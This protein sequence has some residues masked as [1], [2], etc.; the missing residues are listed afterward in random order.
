MRELIKYMDNTKTLIYVSFAS[1]AITFITNIIFRRYRFAKYLPG[2][3][4][5]G[6]GLF[7]LFQVSNTLTSS[8]SISSILLFIICVVGGFIGLL[9][10]LIIGIY[11]KPRHKRKKTIRSNVDKE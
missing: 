3:F 4:F 11:N 9:F 1:I 8:Q 10:A 7:S 6:F 2:I 5:V